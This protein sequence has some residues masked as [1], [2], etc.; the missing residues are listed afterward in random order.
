MF[1]IKYKNRVKVD[2]KIKPKDKI[3]NKFDLL[4]LFETENGVAFPKAY[5]EILGSFESY[6]IYDYRVNEF[7]VQKTKDLNFYGISRLF[8][9]IDKTHKLYQFVA[10][11]ISSSVIDSD[12][13]FTFG[14]LSDAVELFFDLRDM[15]IWRYYL[16]DGSIAQIEPSF[17]A[18]MGKSSFVTRDGDLALY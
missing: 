18:L 4:T 6:I 11:E 5:K 3:M 12:K 9:D 7:G 16:D 13:T 1:K 14:G 10:S 15:S 2:L 17:E 8:E